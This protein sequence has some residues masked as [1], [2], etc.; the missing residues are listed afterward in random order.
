MN[1][2]QNSGFEGGWSTPRPH[3]QVPTSWELDFTE[4]EHTAGEWKT[5]Q[6]ELRVMLKGQLPPGEWE[7]FGGGGQ[8][9]VKLF[10]GQGAIHARLRQRVTGLEVGASY[11]L[12]V[13]TY[14]DT[15]QWDGEKQPPE[16]NE[17]EWDRAAR[18]RLSAHDDNGVREL[19]CWFDE[20]DV[21]DPGDFYLRHWVFEWSFTA[22]A[23]EMVME[24]E[25]WNPWPV[26]NNG[27]FFDNLSLERIN[28][29]A[30][31]P[32]SPSGC[33]CPREPYTRTYVLL[34][35]MDKLEAADWRQAAAIGGAG[36]LLTVGHSA[37]DAGVGPEQRMV[38]AVN[39]EEWGGALEP[40]FAEHYPG[41]E[42]VPITARTPT[43]LGIQLLPPLT[44]DIAQGQ[45]WEQ[46]RGLR[47]GEDVATTIGQYGCFL[48]GLSIMLRNAYERD[49]TPPILD[50]LLVAARVAYWNDNL[51]DWGAAVGLF[52]AFSQSVKSDQQYSGAELSSLLDDGWEI[53]LRRADGEH[54][55]YLENVDVDGRLAIIDTWDGLRKGKSASAYRG[56]R[57]ALVRGVGP[58][59]TVDVPT[60]SFHVQG[61]EEG[62]V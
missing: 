23:P 1:L 42:Y 10:K 61:G 33:L 35:Q 48:T 34:P 8:H 58:P 12:T 25:V 56:I 26:S 18:L 45:S 5:V 32:P 20:A 38:V 6:P 55:V 62:L 49:V 24:I 28:A 16:P 39:P 57:A 15:Y 11:R 36:R 52:A 9:I 19:S 21:G 59:P 54:F 37:D 29:P 30:P 17:D 43:E 51:L 46:W 44:S 53:I 7:L 47:F 40:W 31:P 41:A 13:P 2:L 14:V 4:D 60:V 22:T 50:R 27:W 3:Q